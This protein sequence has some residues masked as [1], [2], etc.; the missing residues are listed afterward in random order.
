MKSRSAVFFA[1][2][3]AVGCDTWSVT[4][5]NFTLTGDVTICPKAVADNKTVEKNGMKSFLSIV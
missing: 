3:K 4:S 1:T 5:C 2:A